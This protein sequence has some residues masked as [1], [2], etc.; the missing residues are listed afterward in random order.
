[1]SSIPIQFKGHKYLNLETFRKSGLG[2]RTPVWFV[3]ELET[4]FVRTS[5]KA[6]KLKRIRNNPSVNIAPCNRAGEL[7]GEWL[8]AAAR[9]I[10]DEAVKRKVAWLFVK[11]FGIIEILLSL[12]GGRNGPNPSI[13]ELKVSK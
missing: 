3:Q 10:K 1:M 8:P 6:G 11:K 9:E 4:I 7:L 2:V 5:A 13:L 12:A